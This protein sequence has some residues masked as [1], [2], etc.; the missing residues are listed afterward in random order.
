MEKEGIAA[1]RAASYADL[2]SGSGP[3]DSDQDELVSRF[4]AACPEGSLENMAGVPSD[5]LV[6]KGTTIL[7][8]VGPTHSSSFLS[9]FL[10]LSV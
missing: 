3:R 9:F 5:I 7:A 1:S 2:P 4:A 8:E 10:L 6:T